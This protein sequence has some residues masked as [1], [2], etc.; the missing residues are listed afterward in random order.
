M[1][2]IIRNTNNKISWGTDKLILSRNKHQL[3]QNTCMYKLFDTKIMK[4]LI[5]LKIQKTYITYVGI[6]YRPTLDFIKYP[7]YGLEKLIKF[8]I[9]HF[10]GET[11]IIN[12]L[13]LNRSNY[14]VISL[15]IKFLAKRFGKY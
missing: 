10:L 13:F 2:L 6:K 14:F 7:F 12:S 1:P 9:S 15:Y 5:L 8:L 4:Q 3:S 11:Y